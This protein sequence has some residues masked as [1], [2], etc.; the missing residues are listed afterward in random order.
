M[1]QIKKAMGMYPWAIQ[2]SG[3][4]A[5]EGVLTVLHAGGKFTDE[6]YEQSG[7]LHGVGVSVVNALSTNMTVEVKRDGKIQVIEFEKGVTSKKL[8][9][10]G[11]S[12][13]TGT[14]VWFKPD[15]EIFDETTYDF[16]VLHKRLKELAYLN[17][18]IAIS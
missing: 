1:E 4:P 17:K 10:T 12:K 14:T 5:V 3:M 16:D 6:G 9:K 7:G 8:R 2:E 15:G 11:M 18:G 13:K